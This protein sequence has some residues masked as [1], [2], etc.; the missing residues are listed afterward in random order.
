LTHRERRYWTSVMTGAA[1]VQ[2]RLATFK[3]AME[4]LSAIGN[5]RVLVTGEMVSTAMAPRAEV[6]RASDSNDLVCQTSIKT[7]IGANGLSAPL[8]NHSPLKILLELADRRGRSRASLPDGT[9]LIASSRQPLLEADAIDDQLERPNVH[10]RKCRSD[11]LF[12]VRWADV[13]DNERPDLASRKV[14]VQ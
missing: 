5:I 10:R 6:P 2:D 9:V 8:S 7:S 11:R 13:D 12:A 4:Q 14:R 1:E 3:Q